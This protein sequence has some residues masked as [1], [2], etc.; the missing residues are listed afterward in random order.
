MERIKIAPSYSIEHLEVDRPSPLTDNRI[1]QLI[2][3][4]L[5]G[6][7]DKDITDKVYTDFKSE[8]TGWLSNS[9][10]NSL[11][12]FDKFSRVDIING[13]TQFIDNLYMQGPVQV[14][15]GDYKYHHRLGNWG[16]KVGNLSTG[17]PLII[18]MPFPSTGSVHGQMKE[19]LDEAK[20][21]GISVHVDGA[22]LTC[23]NGI[24][25][26][27]SHPAIESVGISLSKGLGLGWN[28]IG[29]RWT[30]QT[31]PDSVTI[32]N[33]FHMNNRALVMIGLHFI[34]NLP[35]DYLW[36]T[37]G[38]NYYKICADFALTP[39]KSIYLALKDGHPVG[40]SPLLRYLENASV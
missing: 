34:R 1:E 39:T 15:Q 16:R 32:M 26:D 27:V 8:M 22:W 20:D 24:E 5:S 13:C 7:L 17:V 37:H 33:E 38:E 12:G 21:K 2:Q 25:F 29:L 30:R 28:R 4:V 36:K 19:I 9:K 11:T 18:A 35:S 31:K 23:C 40:V 10:L 6:N 14:L 3:N